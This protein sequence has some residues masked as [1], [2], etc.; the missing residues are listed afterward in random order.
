[1]FH[2][3]E[4]RGKQTQ[5][6]DNRLCIVHTLCHKATLRE[7]EKTILLKFFNS[8][9]DAYMPDGVAPLCVLYYY[10]EDKKGEGN[11]SNM[12]RATTASH[13]L[14]LTRVVFLLVHY[15]AGYW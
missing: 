9:G 2:K 14:V 11:T 13:N 8:Y 4:T 7:R 5:S 1:M 12:C 6:W 15:H 10:K 3:R